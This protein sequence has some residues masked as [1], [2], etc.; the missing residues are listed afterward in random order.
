MSIQGCSSRSGSPVLVFDG[1]SLGEWV[2]CTLRKKREHRAP[3]S[4]WTVVAW[5]VQV[6][7]VFTQNMAHMFCVSGSSQSRT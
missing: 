5:N 4:S 2:K 7:D 6:L 1:L 3:L